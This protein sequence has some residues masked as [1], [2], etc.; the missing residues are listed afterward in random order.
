MKKF[1]YLKIS[2]T[3]KLRYLDNY[4]KKN[5]YVIF[6]PG[7][8]SDIIGDKPQTFLRYTIK[9]KLGFLA[10][11]YSGHG[12]SSGKFTRGN[13][14]R[15]SNDVKTTI[16]K[17][18]KKNNFILIGSSMGAWLS[19][20]QFKYF[21]KQIKGFVGIGSAPEFLTK[22]MWKQFDKKIKKEI[23]EKGI[24]VIKHGEYTYSITRQLIK[25]GK[26]NKVLSK[27]IKMPINV[28]MFHGSKDDIVPVSFSRK[29]LKIFI[30]AK[31]NLIIIKNGDHSLS[32]KKNLKR[33]VKELDKIVNQSAKYSFLK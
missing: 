14:S 25:D 4:Y 31:K 18:V 17:V 20:I 23:M 32:S 8:Q 1:K 30:G 10:L 7:F 11:E 16:K 13:I 6:L 3:K 29:V 2:K 21:R 26:K 28:T 27:K 22:L 15:W 33:I 9:K 24:S 5:L 19:L 12:K